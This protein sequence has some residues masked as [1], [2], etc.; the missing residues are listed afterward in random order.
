VL[1][2]KFSPVLRLDISATLQD[3]TT[4]GSNIVDV[5]AVTL[6]PLSGDLKQNRFARE[7]GRVRLRLYNATWRADCRE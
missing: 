6:K 3:T 1:S 2:M 4:G 7:T 5:D